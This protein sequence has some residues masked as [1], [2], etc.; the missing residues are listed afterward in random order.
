MQPTS[1]VGSGCKQALHTVAPLN[2]LINIPCRGTHWYREVAIMSVCAEA[3]LR[4]LRI[5]SLLRA[6]TNVT[7]NC[8]ISNESR[9]AGGRTTLTINPNL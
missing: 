9:P 2:M 6:E 8:S 4:S 3:A 5:R 7:S 1:I